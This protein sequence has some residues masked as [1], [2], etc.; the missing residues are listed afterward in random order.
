MTALPL[1]PA[2]PTCGQSMVLSLTNKR[3]ERWNNYSMECHYCGRIDSGYSSVFEAFE[4]YRTHAV[5]KHHD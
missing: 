1:L 3:G 4:A 5:R 2:C